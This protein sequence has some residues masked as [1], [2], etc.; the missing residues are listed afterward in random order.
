ML[1]EN[2]RW[3]GQITLEGER[4]TADG[5]VLKRDAVI[6]ARLDKP[7][8]RAS[9]VLVSLLCV[10]SLVLSVT[11]FLQSLQFFD[12]DYTRF[13]LS[14]VPL[15]ALGWAS[16]QLR[17]RNH[18][19][20]MISD[21]SALLMTSGDGNF[22]SMCLEAFERLWADKSRMRASLYLHAA[23]RSVDFGPSG[24]GMLGAT[25]GSS[26]ND[27]LPPMPELPMFD[28]ADEE[29]DADRSG[30]DSANEERVDQEPVN[31]EPADTNMPNLELSDENM[32]R[33]DAPALAPNAVEEVLD[34]ALEP[35]MPSA[36]PP[37]ET[38]ADPVPELTSPPPLPMPTP[39]VVEVP[40][41]ES[42][43]PELSI[44]DLLGA[45]D[46]PE[47]E[48][49][50]EPVFAE[51]PV[52]T[53]SADDSDRLDEVTAG[54]DMF[55]LAIEPEP[56]PD[57]EPAEEEPVPAEPKEPLGP[58]IEAEAFDGI[59][60]KV[61]TLSRLLRNRPDFAEL[62]DAVDV[63][64]KHIEIGCQT[65]GEAEGLAAAIATMRGPLAVYPA[66][67]QVV[68]AVAQAG[69]L[70]RFAAGETSEA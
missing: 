10:A 68:E 14:L 5:I 66:A 40:V 65:R 25:D 47:E 27:P 53:Q 24:T 11:L 69:E 41:E 20:V 54:E 51:Q 52:E 58:A 56:E 62:I 36:L 35:A 16:F 32:T 70:D 17:P 67:L 3:V 42:A 63:L 57:P 15:I 44:A 60:P 50:A 18:L 12:P 55:A 28:D 46:E 4:L 34:V 43:E 22:L 21:G 19:T 49:R 6:G 64:D 2:I 48:I 59:R 26:V 9:F 23:H 45:P 8:V 31:Q 29:P 13:A 38:E 1:S 37:V 30:E 33:V 7:G 39:P 61:A